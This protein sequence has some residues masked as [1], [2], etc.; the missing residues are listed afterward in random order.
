[1]RA[2]CQNL[3]V[4][5]D[6]G[7]WQDG[8]VYV[9]ACRSLLYCIV[10]LLMTLNHSLRRA[11]STGTHSLHRFGYIPNLLREFSAFVRFKFGI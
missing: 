11:N 7:K 6:Q 8:R 4:R 9:A 3:H 10:V 2:G 5:L 1:M